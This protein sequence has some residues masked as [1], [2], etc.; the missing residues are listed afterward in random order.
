MN[1]N[2]DWRSGDTDTPFADAAAELWEGASPLPP[3]TEWGEQVR[4][5]AERKHWTKAGLLKAGTRWTS[6]GNQPALAWRY[7]KGVKFRLVNSNEMR[8]VGSFDAPKVVK[9]GTASRTAVVVEGE[10]DAIRL[11]DTWDADVI[12]LSGAKNVSTEALSVASKY[13][14]VFVATDNDE[15]GHEAARKLVQAL[16]AKAERILPPDGL[17]DWCDPDVL[18]ES[19][20]AADTQDIRTKTT[21]SLAE[22]LSADLG[23]DK[24]NNW[25][26]GS[27]LP[28]RGL[29]SIHGQKKSLKSFVL[30]E[31]ARAI[32]TGTSFGHRHDYLP[33]NPGRV[34]IIQMEV[35][36]FFFRERFLSMLDACTPDEREALIQNVRMVH[37]GD[38]EMPRW[39][40]THDDSW[41]QLCRWVDEAE[42][43]VLLVDP[44][45]RV[46]GSLNV[47]QSHEMDALLDT[48]DRAQKD[49][50]LTVAF[51]HHNRKGSNSPDGDNQVGTQRFSGDP[52]SMCSIY[53]PDS[54]EDYSGTKKRNMH[55]TLRN[56]DAPEMGVTVTSQEGTGWP[57]VRFGVSHERDVTDDDGTPEV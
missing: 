22:L 5:L 21:F 26:E 33:D 34:L 50:G 14:R 53:K 37:M 20:E 1:S 36:P 4:A 12:V 23:E 51:C 35:A 24:D 54:I 25:F 32:A 42:P 9:V 30:L 19:P 45:Q 52:D 40:V 3:E 41:D 48:F 39:R 17:K 28:V 49:L 44:V 16:G 13:E 2:A 38:N 29:L 27:I 43:D 46:T 18:P 11:A 8:N 47:S 31:V 56:G 10:S 6:Y 7:P 15:A 55:W 57:L